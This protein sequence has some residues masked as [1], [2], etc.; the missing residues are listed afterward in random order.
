MSF[1]AI[2]AVILPS[3]K[4]SLYFHKRKKEDDTSMAPSTVTIYNPEKF[5]D[6]QLNIEIPTVQQVLNKLKNVNFNIP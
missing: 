6:S 5:K 2:W 1:T 3:V 4:E